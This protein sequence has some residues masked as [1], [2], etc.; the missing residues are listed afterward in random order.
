[1]A[2]GW[3]CS[4]SPSRARRVIGGPIIGRLIALAGARADLGAERAHVLRCRAHRTPRAAG[5]PPRRRPAGP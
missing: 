4:S 1:V 2:A 5:P 3:R